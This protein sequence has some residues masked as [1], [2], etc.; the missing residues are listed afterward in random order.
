MLGATASPTYAAADALIRI[1]RERVHTTML[2]ELLALLIFLAMTFAFISRDEMAADPLQEK[3][4]K[5]TR[6]VAKQ[7]KQIRELRAQNRELV[8]V[9]R[10]LA[11]SIK[12]LLSTHS[13]TLAANDLLTLTKAHFD[14]MVDDAANKG[15]ILEA[16]QK[17]NAQLRAK[18]AGN[19]GTDLPN[20]PVTPGFIV[21]IDALPGGGF[22]VSPL[23][24][25]NAQATAVKVT[26]L[27]VLATSTPMSVGAFR[28]FAG[29]IKAWGEHQAIPCGFR[30]RMVARHGSLNQFISQQR[31]AAQYFYLAI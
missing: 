1:R 30:A 29:Q 12:R 11:T 10:E 28:N 24:A 20:C 13:G 15:A 7:D 23:W 27:S 16:R 6:Q 22:S 3:V 19:G 17:E 25:Q 21:R 4:E 5:L 2:I 18:L 31:I 8:N 9:N 26:G 14:E